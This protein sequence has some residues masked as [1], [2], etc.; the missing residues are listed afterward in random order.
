MEM[1]DALQQ[2]YDHLL[3][4]L[5]DYRRLIVAYSGG[6]D[7]V[8][9][10]YATHQA[11]GDDMLAVTV[12]TAFSSR[13]EME[14]AESIAKEYGVPHRIITFPVLNCAE[15]SKNPPDRCYHCKKAIFSALKEIATKERFAGVAD[16]GNLND[17]DQHRPGSRALKELG[18]V[19]P[20]IDAELTKAEVRELSRRIGLSTWN[21]PSQSCLATRLTYGTPLTDDILKRI[22]AAEEALRNLGFEQVR[23]RH[24]GEIARIELGTNDINQVQRVR[25]E[26]VERIKSLGYRY[27]CLDLE[28]YRFGSMD[29]GLLD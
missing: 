9:L 1:T 2:K 28:G 4:G 15:I 20:L 17:R 16:G 18:I 25:S 26:V 22:D 6:V 27:V 21:I 3:D 11:L 7:S 12:R 19:S 23:L 24:H 29:E 14:R 8:F 10:A 13:R 5:K